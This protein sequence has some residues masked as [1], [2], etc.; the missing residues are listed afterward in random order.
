MNKWYK[1]APCKGILIVLEHVLAVVMA[2]CIVWTLAYPAGGI[3]SAVLEDPKKTYA[4]SGGFED[5]LRSIAS[6]VV[7]AAPQA[8]QFETDGAYDGDKIVDIKEYVDSSTI[9]NE[10]KS[11]LAYR[12]DDLR[13]W[14]D[15]ST[16]QGDSST[17]NI[18]VCKKADGTF[19]YYYLE[20]FRDEIERG[21]L[22]FANFEEAKQ[23]YGINSPVEMVDLMTQW[24]DNPV[25][26]NL[27]DAEDR[28]IYASC[29]AFDGHSFEER[30]KPIGAENLLDLVNNSPEWN[31]KLNEAIERI[32]RAA[33]SLAWKYT[34]WKQVT[35]SWSEG[36]TNAAY[37]LVDLEKE[38]VYTNRA[39][40]QDAT[41]W[42]KHVEEMKKLGKYI[43][44]TPK[45]ADFSSNLVVSAEQWRNEINANSLGK[46]FVCIF[47][48]DTKYPIQDQF[49]T[50]ND[51]YNQYAPIAREIFVIGVTAG[52]G[53][54]I[55]LV[56]LTI[57]SGRSNKEEGI[58]L[59]LI[60]RAKTELFLLV[61]GGLFI[62]A[63]YA[64]AQA[65]KEV[66]TGKYYTYQVSD[67]TTS[68]GHSVAY[69]SRV[70]DVEELLFIG[71]CAFL[72]CASGLILWLGIIR[73]AKA[74]TLWQNSIIKW[75]GGFTKLVLQH[76]NIIWKVILVFGGF[77][78]LHWI[79]R[80]IPYSLFWTIIMLGAEGIVFI[81]LIRSAIG[82]NRI[83]KGIDEIAGGN[84]EHQID[85]AGLK[86]EQLEIARRINQIGDGLDEALE[87]SMKN[88]RLKTDLIT[89]VSHDIKTPLTS[90]I[91]YIE[92]LKRKNFED[93][94]V[95]NYLK[96]L[97]EKAQRLKTLT[98]DV[99]EA[100]KV[101][102]GNIQLEMMNLN[103]V[104]LINQTSAEFE[105]KFEARNLE[106]IL[107]VPN[108]PVAICADGRRMWRVLAN[109]FNN[110]SKYAM[111]HSRVYVDVYQ[112]EQEV[113][114][115]MK[116][117][118]ERPLNISAEELTE[119]FI[120]GDISR[121]T[122]GSGLGLS[123][124]R[125]LV[126][127]Q[128]GKFELYLDG[129]LFKVAIRFQRVVPEADLS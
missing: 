88:E 85:L 93:P 13:Q 3:R 24:G 96:V 64:G 65:I 15:V 123:I 79:A 30:F 16:Y 18:I 37:L 128:G 75:I 89:N 112:N 121:S 33:E 62:G 54:L 45:L 80:L 25:F 101:S 20:E 63:L 78:F 117:V 107:H 127:L 124:A 74:K 60:D 119:R 104:E 98:E 83:R 27:L 40:Y 82:K 39:E 71:I 12:L 53:L 34:E 99:V 100:S 55:I 95:Q 29:W 46:K 86:G 8:E 28:Q 70:P 35:E 109:I 97:E 76:I 31:G 11:G 77:V 114:L 52:V 10:N 50:E 49:Y 32:S 61:S 69:N 5:Q 22:K 14:E 59:N 19:F 38:K 116:N 73:R 2:V 23:N 111:E 43:V 110:A 41:Q 68:T 91:N 66:L 106:T 42:K 36:N 44:V 115:I 108:E 94:Q 105:E 125:N 48:V 56:W 90:I 103:L 84:V 102:S 7:W 120:R 58:R 4:D 17:S 81:Y 57:V 126:E 9:S 67:V 21:T 92:L 6:R 118:S 1:S 47:A 87:E 113:F 26:N 51:I 122:E 72:I 129:D